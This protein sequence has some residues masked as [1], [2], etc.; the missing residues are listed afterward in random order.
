MEEKHKK[1]HSFGTDVVR[2]LF[3]EDYQKANTI[4]KDAERY[5]TDLI[6]DM[7]K[8]LSILRK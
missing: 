4:Y 7:R 5:S 6:A 1:F 8:I 2:A 3:N